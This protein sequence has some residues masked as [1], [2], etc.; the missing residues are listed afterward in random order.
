MKSNYQKFIIYL[1][2]K[3]GNFVQ[4]SKRNH[5]AKT[6]NYFRTKVGKGFYAFMLWN[7]LIRDDETHNFYRILANDLFENNVSQNNH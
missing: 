7:I 2:L 6:V 1:Y 3:A 5:P 4:R